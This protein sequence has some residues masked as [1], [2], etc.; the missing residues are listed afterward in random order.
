[1]NSLDDIPPK[2]HD[3]SYW[4]LAEEPYMCDRCENLMYRIAEDERD[5]CIRYEPTYNPNDGS[6]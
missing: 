3:C 2:C 6:L 5:Y 4:E 1:M